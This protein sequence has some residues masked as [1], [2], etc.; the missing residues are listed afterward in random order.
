[1]TDRN[2]RGIHYEIS[3]P[4]KNPYDGYY[5]QRV[6]QVDES[7]NLVGIGEQVH[8]SPTPE[9]PDGLVVPSIDL[10]KVG[11][12]S[13]HVAQ[14]AFGARPAGT[15]GLNLAADLMLSGLSEE[16]R[17]WPGTDRPWEPLFD[18]QTGSSPVNHAYG[19]ARGGIGDGNG[20]GQ[21]W[22]ASADFNQTRPI[23]EWEK[24]GQG[25]ENV[26]V[27]D[28]SQPAPR[29]PAWNETFV[30]DSAAAAGIPS[31]NNVFEYGFRAPV[32]AELPLKTPGAT[33][34]SGYVGAAAAAPVPFLPAAPQTVPGG[35]PGLM[36]RAGLND[37]QNP[38][39]PLPGGLAGLIR[40]Y[41]RTIPEAATRR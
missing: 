30:R 33:L 35:I 6:R 26:S 4:V 21:W 12:A 37:P 3:K 41:L 29:S 10:E 14:M 22:D 15:G 18:W 13:G 11:K 16:Y 1:M 39:M 34:G 5:Y 8:R 23:Y 32:P 40:E 7:G 25:F 31:R 27:P 9:S 24:S 20:I 28:L 36:T 38:Y 19:A 2:I 17:S